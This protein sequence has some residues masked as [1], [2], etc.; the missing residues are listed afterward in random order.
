[1]AS[2]F[3]KNEA[4]LKTGGTPLA[5]TASGAHAALCC[6]A[7]NRWNEISINETKLRERQQYIRC[8]GFSLDS[9]AAFKT[10][11]VLAMLDIAL[12]IGNTPSRGKA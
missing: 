12:E 5:N 6:T 4:S 9:P 1:M 7:G 11:K 8:D 10:G 3:L 2:G